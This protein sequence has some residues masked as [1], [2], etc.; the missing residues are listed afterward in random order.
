MEWEG[1]LARL[2]AGRVGEGL[3]KSKR[4]ALSDDQYEQLAKL[5]DSVVQDVNSKNDK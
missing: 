1:Y 2:E 4:D 5:L 3:T